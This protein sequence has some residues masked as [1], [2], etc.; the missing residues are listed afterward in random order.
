MKAVIYHQIKT[1]GNNV[2]VFDV[3]FGNRRRETN[4]PSIQSFRVDR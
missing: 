3:L 4:Q 1:T 2:N